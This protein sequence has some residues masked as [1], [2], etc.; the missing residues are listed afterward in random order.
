[1][2]DLLPVIDNLERALESMNVE[3]EA[4]KSVVEGMN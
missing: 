3:D 4:L 2:N 1:M